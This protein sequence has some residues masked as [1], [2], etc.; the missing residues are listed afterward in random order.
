MEVRR[1]G[2]FVWLPTRLDQHLLPRSTK[3]S[4][5]GRIAEHKRLFGFQPSRSTTQKAKS[6]LSAKK[7]KPKNSW[8][9]DCI[10]LKDSQQCSKPSPEE[11]MEL[12]RMRLGLAELMFDPDGNADH[13]HSVLLNKFPVLATHS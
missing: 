6:K 3:P 9:K 1:G 13:I 7:R 8:R 4:S 12:S 2:V 10:C 5:S 11:K